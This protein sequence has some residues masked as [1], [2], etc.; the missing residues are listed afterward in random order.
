MG[1]LEARPW[2]GAGSGGGEEGP[3]LGARV[4]NATPLRSVRSP[5]G[6]IASGVKTPGGESVSMSE[7][8]LRPPRGFG[9]SIGPGHTGGAFGPKAH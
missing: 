4:R 2:S 5:G 8:K 9:L 6:A 3:L 7:L 1:A